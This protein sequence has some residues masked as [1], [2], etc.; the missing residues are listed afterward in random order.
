LFAFNDF[1]WKYTSLLLF[2]QHYLE[3]EI[4]SPLFVMAPLRGV[5][6]APYR[7]IFARHFSGIDFAVAPFI[8]A[9]G[10]SRI[11]RS[12]FADVLPENNSGMPVVPQLIGKTPEGMLAAC[13]ALCDLGYREVNWN[14]GC[15]WP[16]VIRKQRGSGLLPHPDRIRAVLEHVVPQADCRISIKVRLGTDRTDQLYDAI[17]VLN[18]F[19]LSK[20]I[21]HPRTARQMYEGKVDLEAFAACL[22]EI[23]HAVVYN[24]DIRTAE[25]VHRLAGSFPNVHEWMLGRGLVADPFLAAEI[26]GEKAQRNVET[27]RRFHAELYSCYRESLKHHRSVLGKMKELWFYLSQS[28]REGSATLRLIQR[29]QTLQGYESVVDGFFERRPAIEGLRSALIPQRTSG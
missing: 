23:K 5:T 11:R 7:S 25:D 12:H 4:G 8:S 14:L 21:I 17:P 13:R 9:D 10:V 20:I 3:M 16:F 26:K 29:S 6:T 2:S 19:P 24:G 1:L 27:I 22:R 28:F 15:P 18:E